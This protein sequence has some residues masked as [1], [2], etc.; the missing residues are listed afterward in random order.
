[1]TAA[2]RGHPMPYT[3]SLVRCEDP[4]QGGLCDNDI[5]DYQEALPRGGKTQVFRRSLRLRI[6]MEGLMGD[7][8]EQYIIDAVREK[9]EREGQ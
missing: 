9:M 3:Y 5:I 1:M 4:T 8:D 7:V 6:Q 2:R